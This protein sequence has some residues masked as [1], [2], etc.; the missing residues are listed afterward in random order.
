[1][2][3]PFPVIVAP[4]I[5]QSLRAASPSCVLW[6]P[7]LV[8]RPSHSSWEAQIIPSCSTQRGANVL[9]QLL[10]GIPILYSTRQTRSGCEEASRHSLK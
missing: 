2:L 4:I 8:K 1:M 7:A 6:L 10:R 3:D 5:S 9:A